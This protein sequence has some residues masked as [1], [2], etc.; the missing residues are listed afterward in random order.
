M[1]TKALHTNMIKHDLAIQYVPID[2]L[3][4]APYNPRR[5]NKDAT[6]QLAESIQRYGM[7]DP[8][9]R[10]FGRTLSSARSAALETQTHSGAGNSRR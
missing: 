8:V 4:P 2:L 3:K 10:A 6:A 5:W 1:R 7:V 9:I